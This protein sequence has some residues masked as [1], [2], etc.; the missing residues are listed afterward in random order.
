ML[1][2]VII[3]AKKWLIEENQLAEKNTKSIEIKLKL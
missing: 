3:S 1:V 2:N